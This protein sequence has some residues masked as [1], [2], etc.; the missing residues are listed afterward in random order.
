MGYDRAGR[1]CSTTALAVF[2]GMFTAALA[3]TAP[4]ASAETFFVSG[5]TVTSVPAGYDTVSIAA[6]GAAGGSLDGDA[7]GG[8]GDTVTATLKHYRG[9]LYVCVNSGGGAGDGRSGNG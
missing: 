9:S 2:V 7:P 5:C 4:V 3:V 1:R 6:T 8:K